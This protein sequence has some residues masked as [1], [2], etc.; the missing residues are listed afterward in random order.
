MKLRPGKLWPWLLGFALVANVYLVP[1]N[2]HSPR[3]TD[4]LGLILAADLLRSLL[5]G[6]VAP[7]RLAAVAGLAVFPL[8]WGLYAGAT[9]DGPTFLLAV[10]WLLAAPWAM[11]L[12]R[13][14]RDPDARAA[15]AW[16]LW[17]GAAV[18]VGVLALQYQG[19]LAWTIRMGL[20][21]ADSVTEW[22]NLE[23]RLPG[24]HASSNASGALASLGA[25]AALHLYFASRA[26]LPLVLVSLVLLAA[27]TH[28]TASR[29]PLIVTAVVCVLA[30]LLSRRPRRAVILAATVLVLVVPP[31][32]AYGPP[33]GAVRWQDT[34]SMSVNT[35]ERLMTSG[36]A[37]QLVL[38]HPLGLGVTAG[39]AAMLDRSEIVATH[40][41]LLHVALVFGLPMAAG[42]ALAL[43]GGAWRLLRGL[44]GAWSLP[45]L[46]AVQMLGLFQFEEH[47]N[48]PGFIILCAWLVASLAGS[49]PA[50]VPAAAPVP[51]AAP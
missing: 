6:G 5:G 7:R 49:A 14:A 44:G 33:G 39:R 4:L 24:M 47:L 10:R 26:R 16:G 21:A 42:L 46:L 37:L 22:V 34:G 3:A 28:F 12:F 17:W 27:S 8:A 19:K 30:V 32:L 36:H 43:L 48:N 11:A 25:P 23:M 35:S 20:A 29:S 45:A 13:L 50:P 31:L 40:N 9:G 18:N 15:L 2:A 1:G 41:A 51:E 38:S